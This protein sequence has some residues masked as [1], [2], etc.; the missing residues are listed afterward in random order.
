MVWAFAKD[1]EFETLREQV[2]PGDIVPS[3]SRFFGA[4]FLYRTRSASSSAS[5]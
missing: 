3:I 4:A 1:M 2:A 5:T